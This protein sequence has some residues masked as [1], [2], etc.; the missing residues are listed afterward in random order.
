VISVD[1]APPRTVGA[2][3]QFFGASFEPSGGLSKAF[4]IGPYGGHATLANADG[5]GP[6]LQ[7]PHVGECGWVGRTALCLRWASGEPNQAIVITDEGQQLATGTH[8]T[9]N[10][11]TTAQLTAHR[12]FCISEVGGL[13]VLE[14]RTP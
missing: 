5:S 1:G 2:A 7:L 11:P 3:G 10:W 8:D 4:F 6:W 14:Y 12:L 13:Y 9:S